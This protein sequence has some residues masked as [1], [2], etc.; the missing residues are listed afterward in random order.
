MQFGTTFSHRHAASLGLDPVAALR[1]VI[2]MD[3]S[4]LRL[5][6]YWDE[7]EPQPGEYDFAQ[8]KNLLAICQRHQQSVVLTVGMKAPR[9]PEFYLPDWLAKDPAST[10]AEQRLLLFINRT[11][12]ELG[13]FGCISHWQ[14]ENEP[15]DPSGADNWQLSPSLLEKEIKVVRSMDTRPIVLTAWGNAL[16]RR[17]HLPKLARFG[18]VV[19]IDLYYKQHVQLWKVGTYRPPE[20][21]DRKLASQIVAAGVPV[22]ITELQAEPWEKDQSAYQ[23]DKTPSC[24][25]ILLTEYVARAMQLPVDYIFFWGVEYW[26]WKADRGDDCYLQLWQR[27]A[28]TSSI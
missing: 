12:E 17:Q 9:W 19:G 18:D 20:D 4:L 8:I 7:V 22:W 13:S 21:N 27:L 26:L 28:R 25:D 23:A 3:F 16:S 2:E 5:C 6:V 24:S 1:Q 10:E 11:V 14:V 15:L